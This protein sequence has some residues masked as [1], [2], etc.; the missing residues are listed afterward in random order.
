MEVQQFI[1]IA[2]WTIIFQILNL[3]LLMVLFKK[4]LFKPVT[5]ILES[6]RLKSKAI[7]RKPSR[8]RR[9]RRR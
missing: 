4:Y 9:M 8:P 3:L 1:S 5:E 7:I 2:P 6:V